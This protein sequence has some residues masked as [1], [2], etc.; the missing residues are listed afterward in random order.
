MNRVHPRQGNGELVLPNKRG[1]A[2]LVTM[3][4]SLPLSFDEG[5]YCPPLARGHLHYGTPMVVVAQCD[6]LPHALGP[7]S[8]LTLH[9]NAK[10]RERDVMAVDGERNRVSEPDGPNDF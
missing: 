5:T 3:S 2:R 10:A 1:G 8:L 6:V 7:P 9:P 4:E